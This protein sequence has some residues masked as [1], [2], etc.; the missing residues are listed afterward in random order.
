MT[1]KPEG[2]N[3][4]N[5]TFQILNLIQMLIQT[6]ESKNFEQKLAYRYHNEEKIL[7]LSV[8]Y[9]LFQFSTNDQTSSK[10]YLLLLQDAEVLLKLRCEKQLMN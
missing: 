4:G 2:T 10:L 3:P 1:S 6:F 9:I 5:M 8:R 7:I